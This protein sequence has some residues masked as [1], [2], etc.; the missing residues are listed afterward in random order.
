MPAGGIGSFWLRVECRAEGSP[1]NDDGAPRADL[2]SCVLMPEAFLLDAV[3]EMGA[4]RGDDFFEPGLFFLVFSGLADL[5][6]FF[7]GL[8][9]PFGDL[10][11]GTDSERARGLRAAAT[12]AGGS[13]GGRSINFFSS[14]GLISLRMPSDL[15]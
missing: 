2:V 13:G 9:P 5:G 6:E 12:G 10:A 14:S 1:R 15:R 3:T 7:D 4:G 11:A 8:A